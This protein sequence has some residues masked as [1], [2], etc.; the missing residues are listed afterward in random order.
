LLFF[1][2]GTIANGG[3]EFLFECIKP[4]NL[5]DSVLIFEHFTTLVG[6]GKSVDGSSPS[7][8]FGFRGLVVSMHQFFQYLAENADQKLRKQEMSEIAKKK[9]IEKESEKYK[10][11]EKKK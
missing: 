5:I 4:S 11:A 10:L 7:T 1:V 8:S 2:Q 6:G 9:K 3:L